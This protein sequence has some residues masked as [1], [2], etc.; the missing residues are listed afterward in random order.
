MGVVGPAGVSTPA[1]LARCGRRQPE[2]ERLHERVKTGWWMGP[3]NR[4]AGSEVG[5]AREVV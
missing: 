2:G 5:A 3:W 4:T 1:E